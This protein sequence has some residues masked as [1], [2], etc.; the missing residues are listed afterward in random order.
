VQNRAGAQKANAGD[1]LRRN[2]SRVTVGLARGAEPHLGDADR[3][4]REQR[5]ANA[6]EDVGA[7]TSGLARELALEP[8]DAAKQRG[9]GELAEDGEM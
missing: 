8:H 5:R 9:E 4:L 7:Q 1:D 3:Q 2:A 6:D